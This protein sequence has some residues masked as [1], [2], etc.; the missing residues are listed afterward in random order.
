M[1]AWTN[2]ELERIGG[3]EELQITPIR[4]DGTLAK[5]VTIWVVRHGDN[6]YV[7]SF[8][9]RGAAWFRRVKTRPE[10]RIAAG[11]VDKDVTFI[12]A[13]QAIADQIDDVYRTKYRRYGP[14]YVDPMV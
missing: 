7:R 14:R 12:D 13:D 9:G 6:L 1:A 2:T 5:P 4:R 11:G 10:G 8:K 3:A